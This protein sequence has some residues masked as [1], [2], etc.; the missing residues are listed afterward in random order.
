MKGCDTFTMPEGLQAA[1]RIYPEERWSAEGSVS[2]TKRTPI[3]ALPMSGYSSIICPRDIDGFAEALNPSYAADLPDGRISRAVCD[4]DRA[5]SP[6]RADKIACTQNRNLRGNST[7]IIR[8]R[9]LGKNIAS[10]FP[11][12]VVCSRHPVSTKGALR[13]IVTKRGAGCGGRDDVVC[14]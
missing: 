6:L 4:V 3:G 10:V 2:I 11:K 9:C 1:G 8:S 7:L 14:A 13:P 5:R 12:Y